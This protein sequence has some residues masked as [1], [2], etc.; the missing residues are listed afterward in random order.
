MFANHTSL[1]I[2]TLLAALLLNG[3]NSTPVASNSASRL[4][5][6]DEDALRWGGDEIGGAPYMFRD[7][8]N[9][10][11][12][13][14]F[15]KEIADEIGN[16]LDR[17]MQFIHAPWDSLIPAL[18]RRDFHFALS[19]I[20]VTPERQAL[21]NFTEPYYVCTKQWIVRAN[22]DDIQSLEDLQD[23]PVGTLLESTSEHYLRKHHRGEIRT[24]ED[25]QRP[26]DELE[27]GEIDGVLLDLPIAAFYARANQ[28]LRLIGDPIA[29]GQYAIAVRKEDT[30]LLQ[31]LNRVLSEMKSDGTLKQILK[32]WH[33]WNEAQATDSG[34]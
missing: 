32:N 22:S 17:Q 19:G 9:P 7:P 29:P 6:N 16:R 8:D 25:A 30:E 21:V 5:G 31:E 24:Y 34:Q 28:N 2:I 10:S 11:R 3:C 12:H 14:G 23:R 4:P 15:E 27:I 20:E 18:N 1:L 13:I 33:L 26:Y